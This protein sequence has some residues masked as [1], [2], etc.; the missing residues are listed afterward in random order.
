MLIQVGSSSGLEVG[1]GEV[2]PL[3][4]LHP[5]SLN[6]AKEQILKIQSAL[7]VDGDHP[8]AFSAAS[9]LA[10]DGT[11]NEYLRR[12]ALF[13]DIDAFLPSVRSGLEMALL[14]FASQLNGY[15]LHQ[16]M[17]PG[18]GLHTNTLPVNGIIVRRSLDTGKSSSGRKFP[19]LKVKVGHQSFEDDLQAVSIAYR[20]SETYQSASWGRIRADAN[21]AWNESEAMEFVTS[22]DG[23]ALHAIER[24]EF[25]EEPLEEAHRTSDDL[26]R[27]EAQVEALERFYMHSGIRY[28]LDETIAELVEENGSDFELIKDSLSAVFGGGQRGCAAFVLKPALLGVELS[29]RIARLARSKLQ[30]GCVFSSSFDTGVGLAYTALLG[31][32]SDE[33]P[34]LAQRFPHGVGTFVLQPADTLSPSFS[35]YVNNDGILNLSSLSRALYGLTLDD[36][37]DSLGQY[38]LLPAQ[39]QFSTPKQ[40]VSQSVGSYEAA[41]SSSARGSKIN[42]VVSLPLP[43]SA[44]IAASRFTDLPQQSRWS[45]WISSVAYQGEETEWRLNVKGIPLTWRAKSQLLVDPL[46]IE[47]ESVSGVSNKGSVEFLEQSIDACLMK[48]QI[49]MLTP[50]LLRPLFQGTSVF[51]EEF[52]RDKLLRWSLEMFRDVVKADLALERGDVELGDALYSAVE[53]KASAI[54]ATLDLTSLPALKDVEFE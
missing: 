22:I 16:S 42:V 15:P 5:E 37:R 29:L 30:I 49:T 24:F 13:A 48:V 50:R 18:N 20:R 39:P 53:G 40:R 27:M 3:K 26:L 19:S 31:S 34:S 14:S 44:Q 52:I 7:E 11:M 10:M 1:L 36:I 35:S 17:S 9:I 2:S 23:V 45:P 43:F 28:A 54:E 8:P 32:L 6:D 41:T 21:R 51:L 25:V 33:V 38:S 46:G 4:G 12:L 47:W